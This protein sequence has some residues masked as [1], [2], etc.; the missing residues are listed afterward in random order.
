MLAL[1]GDDVRA[2]LAAW[3]RPL[4]DDPDDGSPDG[5]PWASLALP[6]FTLT[7]VGLT[8][9]IGLLGWWGLIFNQVAVT[10]L[11]NL[12]PQSWAAALM[13]FGLEPSTAGP[14]GPPIAELGIL[15]IWSF[16]SASLLV[17]PWL[18]NRGRPNRVLMIVDDLDRCSPDEMLDVIEGM[19]LLVD[20]QQVNRR[21]QI[22]ML[23]DEAVLAHSIALRYHTMIQERAADA[24]A[25]NEVAALRT[26]R[27]E[28]VAEQNE[29]LFACHL[30]MGRL[31]DSDVAALV[32][33]LAGAEV[34][35]LKQ[36]QREQRAA[37]LQRQY[38]EAQKNLEQAKRQKQQADAR[39]QVV[40]GGDRL[41]PID[42]DAP[43]ERQPPLSLRL[44]VTGGEP[45][46]PTRE[47]ARRRERKND[48]IKAW[49]DAQS[50]KTPEERLAERPEVIREQEQAE[51]NL[52]EAQRQ[53][54]LFS[55][56]DT[57]DLASA[58][59][60]E[61]PFQTD[62]VRF[63]DREIE[64]LQRLLPGYFRHIG[65]RPSPRAIRILLFKIQICRLLLQLL[66][67]W[68]PAR[69][70]SV[71]TILGAFVAA[72]EPPAAHEKSETET[73]QIARQVV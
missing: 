67:P 69:T 17:W 65:R 35:A 73:L 23:V 63:T 71:E 41:E 47:E 49:N 46:P 1:V 58:S 42:V 7:A 9:L 45:F 25:A 32:G 24:R 15:V 59:E 40:A 13:A 2:L 3:V 14:S 66:Y 26:A 60:P 20:D 4:Q 54:D 29:K 51:R 39:V 28:V 10:P 21:L 52:Q 62:D 64:Q 37:R 68:R 11:L 44:R 5:F 16:L 34:K 72:S 57:A 70:R 8:W 18:V 19:R 50:R 38:Q 43:S 48:E 31:T 27:L 6:L 12:L 53:F 55:P 36:A 30:R 22:L 61:V 33:S 56:P